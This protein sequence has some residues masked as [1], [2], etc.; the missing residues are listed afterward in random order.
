MSDGFFIS[1]LLQLN[2]NYLLFNLLQF[3]NFNTKHCINR[4]ITNVV[5]VITGMFGRNESPDATREEE[6]CCQCMDTL[7]CMEK[8]RKINKPYIHL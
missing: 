7:L 3:C 8:I 5:S 4:N 2:V 1:S 6:I